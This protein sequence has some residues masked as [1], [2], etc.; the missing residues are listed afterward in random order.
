MPR[1]DNTHLLLEASRMRSDQARHRTLEA[2]KTLAADGKPVNP[3]TVA[4]QAGVSR[5]WLYTFE[6]AREAM[7]VANTAASS[8]SPLPPA[9]Q[10]STASWR[11]RVEALTD[12][13]ERLRQRVRELE[14]RLAALYGQWRCQPDGQT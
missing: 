10:P 11:R 8:R 12:D 2:I 1:A 3:T 6:E 14:E 7:S 5:Q 13:N 9:Q 4:R